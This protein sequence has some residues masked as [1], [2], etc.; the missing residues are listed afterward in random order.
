ME[1]NNILEVKDLHVDIKLSEGILTAVRGVNFEIKKAVIS[2]DTAVVNYSD[3]LVTNAKKA[4]DPLKKVSVKKALKKGTDFEVILTATDAVK[5]TE[6]LTGV[7]ADGKIP[8]GA[9]GIFELKIKGLGNYG[10]NKTV[11]FKIT[12]KNF[13]WFWNLFQ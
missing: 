4:V 5:N 2:E 3:Q 12:T 7:L 11:T 9:T 10:G 1:N 6:A 13:V 8:A